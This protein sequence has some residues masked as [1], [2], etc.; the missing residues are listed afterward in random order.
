MSKKQCLQQIETNFTGS[1]V[2]LNENSNICLCISYLKKC[3]LD[4][5]IIRGILNLFVKP[6]SLVDTVKQIANG[7]VDLIVY[8]ENGDIPNEK[9][10][11]DILSVFI[12]TE[13]TESSCK[14]SILLWYLCKT[15]EVYNKS[16]ENLY[17]EGIRI[18][19]K[20][21]TSYFGDNID[22]A[23]SK[24]FEVITDA[25]V[26]N[27]NGFLSKLKTYID[28]VKVKT[29]IDY[30]ILRYGIVEQTPLQH[31]FY[32]KNIKMMQIILYLQFG[33]DNQECQ[34]LFKMT[35]YEFCEKK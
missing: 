14:P 21:S 8:I 27:K 35:I 18:S 11:D 19:I 7:I 30:L 22:I 20:K 3:V 10:I 1:C 26:D 17:A 16:N 31:A 25:L 2:N 9:T 32:C 24:V 23:L 29:D 34:T 28:S 13:C 6:A 12:K 33:I 4:S 15:I 5:T